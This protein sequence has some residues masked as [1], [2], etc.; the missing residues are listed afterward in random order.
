MSVTVMPRS[1]ARN[2]A[3]YPP[4]PPPTT[5]MFLGS[6]IKALTTGDTEEHRVTRF[7]VFP[8]C[9]S[10]SSVV[11]DLDFDLIYPWTDSKNGCSKASAIQRRKRAA[12]APS[13][14]R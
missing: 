13:I 9:F 8:L 4:G 5:A 2:A 10:V 1:A 3:A 11:H 6:D 7:Q 14:R 12:S